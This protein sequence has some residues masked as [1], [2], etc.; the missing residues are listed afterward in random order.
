MRNTNM[1]QTPAE[2]QAKYRQRRIATGLKALTLWLPPEALAVL[3]S[4]PKEQ[5]D[6]IAAQAILAY[7]GNVTAPHSNDTHPTLR[8]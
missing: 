7:N 5:R 8:H 6:R 2:R 3:E 1:T 4:Y